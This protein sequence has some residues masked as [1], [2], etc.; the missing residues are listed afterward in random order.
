[1]NKQASFIVEAWMRRVDAWCWFVVLCGCSGRIQI[2]NDAP[3][4]R[5]LQPDASAGGSAGQGQA[6]S[7]GG[8]G[9]GGGTD[10]V[11]GSGEEVVTGGGGAGSGA[12]GSA[13]SSGA[14]AGGGPI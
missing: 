9:T 7:S 14:G 10:G 1:M 4:A 3:D 6:G 13:G 12:G 5:R 8:I 11:D 2:G